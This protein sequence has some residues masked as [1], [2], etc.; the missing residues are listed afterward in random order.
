[1][2]PNPPTPCSAFFWLVGIL[3]ASLF[4]LMIPPL[5]EVYAFTIFTSVLFQELFRWLYFLVF[6]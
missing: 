1:M 4:W 5:Y 2:V 6:V 3:F